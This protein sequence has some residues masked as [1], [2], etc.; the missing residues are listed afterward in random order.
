MGQ[1]HT[2]TA[3][4]PPN[5]IKT[6]R[7]Q[8]MFGTTLDVSVFNIL[9][10]LKF[11]NREITTFCLSANLS[12]NEYLFKLRKQSSRVKQLACKIMDVKTSYLLNIKKPNETCFN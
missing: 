2:V 3:K 4:T 11:A 7:H 9:E 5:G 1:Y 6:F 8:N 10:H 12:T